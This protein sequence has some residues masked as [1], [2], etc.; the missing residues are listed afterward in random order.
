MHHVVINLRG[1]AH[2]LM[3]TAWLW[4]ELY[5]SVLKL[6]GKKSEEPNTFS[7]HQQQ[8]DYYRTSCNKKILLTGQYLWSTCPLQFF[9][10]SKNVSHV[11]L[12]QNCKAEFSCILAKH[13]LWPEACYQDGLVVLA[14]FVT[15][16]TLPFKIWLEVCFKLALNLWSLAWALGYTGRNWTHLI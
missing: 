13:L 16:Q 3:H 2:C 14:M 6:T 10:T 5:I 1:K 9:H 7:L 15:S 11:F 8:L 4:P 12:T